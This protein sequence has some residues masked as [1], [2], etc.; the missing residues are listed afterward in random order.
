MKW[1]QNVALSAW[2]L[3]WLKW[4][5]KKLE[6][7]LKNLKWLKWVIEKL[8]VVEVGYWKTW[9]GWSG[10]IKN[11]KWLKWVNEKL[12]V[13]EVGHWKSWSGWSGSLYMKW[14][15]KQLYIMSEYWQ[16]EVNSWSGWSGWSGLQWVLD[17]PKKNHFAKR[18]FLFKKVSPCQN[19]FPFQKDVSFSKSV[20]F[21]KCVSFQHVRGTTLSLASR[22][23]MT[24]GQ[25]RPNC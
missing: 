25:P 12:E 7:A 11:L 17:A 4:V 14:L 5:N 13:V 16:N 2:N 6:V 10:S 19:V 9:C 1:Y 20:S 21:S 22:L 3:K 23:A 24:Q 15:S 18:C 8:E